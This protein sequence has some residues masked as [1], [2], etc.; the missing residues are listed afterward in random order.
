MGNIVALVITGVCLLLTRTLFRKWRRDSV[1]RQHGC[2][3]PRSYP[4]KEP[5]LGLNLFFNTG[6]AIQGHRYLPELTHRYNTL[7]NTFQS[8]TLGSVSINSIDPE[9]L[10]TVF[11]TKSNDWGVEPVRL[12]A[13]FPFC[14]RGFIT[15]DGTAWEHSRSLLRPSFHKGNI[16]DL[17]TF[18]IHVEKI[19]DRIPK[20]GS[21]VDLQPLFYSLVRWALACMRWW[22][23]RANCLQYLDTATLFLF[24]KSV[25]SLSNGTPVETQAFLQAFDHALLGSGVRI[26]LGPFKFLYPYLDPKWLKSC[27]ITHGFIDKHVRT[28]LEHRS[29]RTS[30]TLESQSIEKSGRKSPIL[31]HA[32]AE[33]TED[34][35]ELRNE[36]MQALIAAQETTA[37]LISNV[38]FLLSRHPSVWQTLRQEVTALGHEEL[39][40]DCLQNL[41]YLDHVL[42]ECRF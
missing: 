9:N 5:F 40:V 7:G 12:P 24:G 38:F 10:H 8:T 11:S 30:G 6:N 1:S 20:D 14:G 29:L 33:Q 39:N 15:T 22:I 2:Q 27:A 34:P 19:L 16:V 35:I 3:S 37:A 36:I 13:Q 32:L 21:M 4:H 17:P 23:E 41:E 18:G 42:N 31:L 28:A 26:A 25:D